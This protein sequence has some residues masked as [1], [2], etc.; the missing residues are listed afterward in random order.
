M[1]HN[2]R[3]YESISE[4]KMNYYCGDIN[5][6]ANIEFSK[7]VKRILARSSSSFLND[8]IVQS[9]YNKTRRINYVCK[10]FKTDMGQRSL[11]YRV[12]TMLNNRQML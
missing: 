9:T 6:L 7:L 12:T 3:K 11:Q 5:N 10:R 2:K 1:I 8:L 4:L